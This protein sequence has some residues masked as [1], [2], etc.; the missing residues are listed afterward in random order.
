MNNAA[1]PARWVG[2]VALAVAGALLVA[3]CGGGNNATTTGTQGS[4]AP[5][6]QQAE[7]PSAGGHGGHGGTF[8]APPPAPLRE[9]ERFVDV[10]LAEPY[11]PVAPN[12]GTDEYRCFIVDPGLT[13]RSFLTGSQFFPQNTSLVHHAIIFRI[14]PDKVKQARDLDAKTPGEGWTCFGD[15]GVDGGGWVGHWAPGANETLLKQKVGYPLQP[16]SMLVMQ[17]HYNLLAS[18]GKA[19]QSD[20]SSMRLRLTDGKAELKPLITGLLQAPIELPC[21][22]E[23]SGPLCDRDT[24]VK[25]VASRFGQEAGENVAQLAQYCG[26]GKPLTP[27]PTQH[28]D[29]NFENKATVYAVAGHMHLLGRSIKVEV[30][31]DTPKAKT[32][33][34]I[35][36]YDF[37]DQQIRP[38]PEPVTLQPKDNLRVTCT[39]DAGLRKTLPALKGQ[40]ARYVV[41]GD[42][43]SDEMCLGL[44]ILSPEGR[45]A[46]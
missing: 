31:P 29:M 23:E 13:E 40:P 14:D 19:D 35:P 43:T 6:S 8:S 22:S 32:L 4:A 20:Q 18:Q 16:G 24:A 44:L 7:T 33:L 12:G 10:K 5:S 28:C 21:T 1:R 25:D 39:H 37:D 41:W 36:A 9:S 30:N 15:S 11:K 26:K 17:I 3:S 46:G 38:L 34:D 27:G 2:G 42:G 45:R